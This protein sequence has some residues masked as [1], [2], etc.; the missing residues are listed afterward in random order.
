MIAKMDIYLLLQSA[1]DIKR[2][3]EKMQHHQLVD[4]ANYTINELEI[5]IKEK[6]ADMRIS[7]VM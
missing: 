6:P 5:I 3:A 2:F 7:A 4:C 1:H